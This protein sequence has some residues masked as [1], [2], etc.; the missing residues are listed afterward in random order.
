MADPIKKEFSPE[1]GPA[2]IVMA[3]TSR[4]N[5]R[6]VMCEHSMMKVEKKDFDLNLVDRMGDFLATAPMVDLTGLGEPLLSK[7]FW[8]VLD[9]YPLNE[10]ED[11]QFFLS[12][13]TNGTRLT[14]GHIERLLRSRVRTIR[15]SID[16]ADEK[17]FREIRKTDL[18]PIL[19]GTRRLIEARNASKRQFPVV[20]IHMTWMRKTLH[21][22][23][24]MIDLSKELGADF[25]DVFP[26]H[27]RS[28]GTLDTWIQLDGG[29]YNYRDNL[30]SGVPAAE[31]ER[32][33]EEFHSYASSMGQPIFSTLHDLTGRRSDDFPHAAANLDWDYREEE[34]DW[35]ENSIRCPMPFLE[36][37]VHYEGAVHPCCWSLRPAGNLRD[38]TLEEIWTGDTMGEVRHDLMAGQVP[39]LCAGAG[40]PFVRGKGKHVAQRAGHW[41]MAS[42]WG[43]CRFHTRPTRASTI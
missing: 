3:V 13:A 31:L 10:I 14:P 25:L 2:Q 17:T 8:E 19:D 18:A 27:E 20:G 12:F 15:V 34:I 33:V 39:K 29:S 4:C 22:V 28:S 41:H 32:V 38:E 43:L 6:C 35:K 9:R 30:M 36:M 26:L 16:A 21:G 37:F 23:P 1:R 7:T 24:A 40:C 5:L 11:R 42:N